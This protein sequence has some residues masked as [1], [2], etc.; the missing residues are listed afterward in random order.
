MLDD[1]REL[2]KRHE[3]VRLHQIFFLT[4]SGRARIAPA[5]RVRFFPMHPP[6]DEIGGAFRASFVRGFED[7]SVPK[8]ENGYLR[9]FF[10][11][12]SWKKGG[13][14]LSGHDRC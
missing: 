3:N 13:L 12:K 5:A 14:R 2:R 9:L 6:S 7:N 4:G 11:S 10:R 8:I 1:R